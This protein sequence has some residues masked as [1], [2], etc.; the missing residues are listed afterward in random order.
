VVRGAEHRRADLE[1]HLGK[2][3]ESLERYAKDQ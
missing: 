1:E 2:I 3:R